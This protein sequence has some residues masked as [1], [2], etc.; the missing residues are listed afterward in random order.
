MVFSLRELMWINMATLGI[1]WM[2]ANGRL[3]HPYPCTTDMTA[4]L[5]HVVI[6]YSPRFNFLCPPRNVL[7]VWC[8]VT[9]FLMKGKWSCLG[10]YPSKSTRPNFL[11]NRTRPMGISAVATKARPMMYINPGCI[12]PIH[13]KLNAKPSPLL[14]FFKRCFSFK[15]GPLLLD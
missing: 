10:M 11:R 8:E 15:F 5:H 6:R 7:H 1:I 12:L 4:V 13:A 9:E 3:V 2:G 14:T